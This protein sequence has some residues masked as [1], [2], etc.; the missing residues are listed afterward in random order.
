M[1]L[2]LVARD[3][4][5]IVEEL[6]A[7]VTSNIKKYYT[8][9]EPMEEYE[10][11]EAEDVFERMKTDEYFLRCDCHVLGRKYPYLSAA[12]PS[13]MK[14]LQPTDK[15]LAHHRDC[16]FANREAERVGAREV[17][18]VTRRPTEDTL[19]VFGPYVVRREASYRES[20]QDGGGNSLN[21][22]KI[23][24][25]LFRLLEAAELNIAPFHEDETPHPVRAWKAAQTLP[26]STQLKLKR[27]LVT[28]DNS[29]DGYV[30]GI[31]HSS[32]LKAFIAE[33]ANWSDGTRPQ[34][35]LCGVAD[36]YRRRNDIFE[37]V[38]RG[39]KEGPFINTRPHV[40]G[41]MAR[42]TLRS[43]YITILG[44]AFPNISAP[45][46]LGLRSF[47]QPC[48]KHDDWMPVDSDLERQTLEI[49][50]RLQ[51][52]HPIFRISICKP[53]FDVEVVLEDS[54]IGRCKPDFVV[55]FARR[56][57]ERT[58]AIETMGMTTDDY[59][60]RK[61]RTHPLMLKRYGGLI[62]HRFRY[63]H[64]TVLGE[65]FE[66]ELLGF[67]NEGTQPHYDSLRDIAR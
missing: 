42:S 2:V 4:R 53:L 55:T 38:I 30:R 43:P 54:A 12:R 50:K 15:N 8:S 6:S 52:D 66:H 44:Y 31:N 10:I 47:M 37:L 56:G 9:L 25:V 65:Q 19:A 48:Y 20:N 49:L 41:G 29:E 36:G 14:R 63:G 61:A 34:G 35:F 46:V 26:L 40:F 17:L 13:T 7:T 58:V 24:S 62:Q 45:K 21:L 5:K 39:W 59:E 23:S 28:I 57:E 67:L 60:D 27:R 51:K 18:P 64:T 33:P 32:S 3:S 16:V 22:P 11:G 1:T